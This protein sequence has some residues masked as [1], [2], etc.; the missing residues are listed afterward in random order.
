MKRPSWAKV[1][2]YKIVRRGN[3][4]GTYQSYIPVKQRASSGEI[5]RG[6]IL[7]YLLEKITKSPNGVCR[8]KLHDC[9][10]GIHARR[11]KNMSLEQLRVYEV[12]IIVYAA[13]WYGKGDKQR[14]YKVWV[15]NEVSV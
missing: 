8:D 3:L 9:C 1:R 14:A 12:V 10:R 5:D 6:S 13:K 11:T 15:G 7:E 2:R 4:A